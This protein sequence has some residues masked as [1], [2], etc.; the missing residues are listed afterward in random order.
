LNSAGLSCGLFSSIQANPTGEHVADGTAYY[1]KHKHDGVI[2]FGGGSALDAGKAVALMV[3]QD[4]PIW[5][6]EDVGDNWLR[7]N[8]KGMAPVVA[9]PTTAG[10]GSEVGR[11]SV[12]T[13]QENH[14]K[15]II[16]HPNMLPAQVILD[17]ELTVGLPPSITA[18]TGMDAL[19]HNLEALCSPFYHPMAMGI[20]VEGIRLVQEYLPRAVADGTDIEARTQML[21]CS[22]MGAT[23]FQKGLRAMH[24]LAHPLGGLYNA[25][26]GMVNAILM[27]YVLQAN[28]S[29]IEERVERLTRYMGFETPG[30]DSFLS[31]VVELRKNLGIPHTLA[32]I[33]IDATKAATV[34]QMATEDPSAGGN[35]ISFTVDEYQQIFENAVHGKL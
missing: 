12:I 24:A 19:S 27:P 8:E 21:V 11:A 4:R 34:A 35:P 20:A 13:D 7:V 14:I 6:F 10:T 28:R 33:D 2:A 3:G 9:I 31:W 15:K 30:F 16:F 25:H 17:P 26:H 1:L 18:A 32:E 5:D 23:A 22:S 29:A